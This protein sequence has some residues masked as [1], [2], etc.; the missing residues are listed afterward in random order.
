MPNGIIFAVSIDV[1]PAIIAH[2]VAREPAGEVGR[3]VAIR[4]QNQTRAHEVRI[5]S[6][7]A[8][9]VSLWQCKVR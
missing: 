8:D 9:F 1:D 7:K 4:A 6:A 2:R 5:E 3:V